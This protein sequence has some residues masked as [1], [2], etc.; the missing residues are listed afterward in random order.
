M[1][2][3]RRAAALAAV[4]LVGTLAAC[5][6]RPL[7]G[8]HP[9]AIDH[10]ALSQVRVSPLAD[11]GGQLLYTHLAKSMH[12]HGPPRNPL[13]QLDI[14]LDQQIV[15]LGIR[16]DETATRA[17]LTLRAN[18]RLRDLRTGNVAFKGRSLI[19]NSYNILESRF[20]TIA[21]E[22]DARARATRVL[23]D[24]IATRVAIFLSQAKAEP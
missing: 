7:Y 15:D 10:A 5:G 18:F 1:W 12:P 24:N 14:D 21:S 13:W 23:G 17:N 9:E 4:A 16:K 8:S 19:T 22:R 20:G 2:W 11:R 3:R 6:F